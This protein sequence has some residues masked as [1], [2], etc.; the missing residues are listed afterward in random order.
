LPIDLDGLPVKGEKVG[1]YF[2]NLLPD[3]EAIRRRIQQ[4]T[5][6]TPL[7]HTPRCRAGMSSRH[8]RARAASQ[9]LAAVQTGRDSAADR[10]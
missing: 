1:F 7:V 3:S 9:L 6:P 2:D 5:R 4:S 8:R 10:W